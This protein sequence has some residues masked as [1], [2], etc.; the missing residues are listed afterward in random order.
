MHITC[1][2]TV[3]S[4]RFAYEAYHRATQQLTQILE[5]T[6]HARKAFTV[7]VQRLEAQGSLGMQP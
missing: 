3:E 6:A 2:A 4:G 1:L 7:M 5:L